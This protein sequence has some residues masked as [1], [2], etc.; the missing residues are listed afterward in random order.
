MLTYTQLFP[1]RNY[2]TN[3]FETTWMDA[4]T[5]TC[6]EILWAMHRHCSTL[7]VAC[8]VG[9]VWKLDYDLIHS[10][11]DGGGLPHEIL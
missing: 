8:M 5:Y 2:I 11:D 3:A 10:N 4:I 6:S 1:S 9:Q 7:E